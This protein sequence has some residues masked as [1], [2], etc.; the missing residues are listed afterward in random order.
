MKGGG[1]GKNGTPPKR[2]LAC[3]AQPHGTGCGHVA[4]HLTTRWDCGTASRSATR[5]FRCGP[6]CRGGPAIPNTQYPFRPP[7]PLMHPPP[8]PPVQ[9]LDSFK[10]RE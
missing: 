7:P 9:S 8:P 3:D 6:Q 5:N 1:G 10:S 4:T 2:N